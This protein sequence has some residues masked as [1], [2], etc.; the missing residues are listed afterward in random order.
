MDQL[1]ERDPY[2]WEVVLIRNLTEDLKL[3][4]MNPGEKDIRIW[5]P[6]SNGYFSS[7]SFLSILSGN[8]SI[9]SS[10][11]VKKVWG[12]I[13]PPQIKAFSW[14]SVLRKQN[15]M[16]AL[17]HKRPFFAISPFMCP[18]MQERWRI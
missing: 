16:D 6:S 17:Q 13:A 14:V 5:S 8:L 9:P 18:L 4:F 12:S 10:F 1:C 11:L 7:K 2:E 3:I 15:S